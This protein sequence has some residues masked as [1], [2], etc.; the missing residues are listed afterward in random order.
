[1]RFHDVVAMALLMIRQQKTRTALSLIGVVIGSLM[2]LFSLASRRGVQDAVARV[3]SMSKEMRQIEVYTSWD[4]AEQEVPEEELEVHGEVDEAMRL[5]IREMLFRRWQFKHAGERVGLTRERIE[6]IESLQ[7]VQSVHPDAEI[8]VQLMQGQNE[9][10]ARGMAVAV[11]DE[12]LRERLLAGKAFESDSDQSILLNE[13]V[14]WKWGR[15]SPAKMHTLLGAKVRIEQRHGEE[16]VA[17]SITY[18][19]G[20]EIDFSEEE[21]SALNRAL[22]HIPTI[23][24]QLPLPEAERAALKKAFPSSSTDPARATESV[25]RI[26]SQEFTVVGIFRGPNKDE[27]NDKVRLGRG[28]GSAEFLLPLKTA[29]RLAPRNPYA[30]MVGL[31]G[32][33]VLVDHESHLETVSQQIRAMGLAEQSM[34][35]MVEYI[36]AR[37]RQV[38]LIVSL[39]AVFALVISALGITNTMVMS[40]V[41]RTREIGIMKALGARERQIQ[42]LFLVEGSLLGLIGGACAL[43]IGLVIRYPIESLT[44]SILENELHKTFEQQHLFEFP[45]WLLAIVLAFSTVVTTLAT[46]LPAW[47]AARIDPIKALRHD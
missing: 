29:T 28:D 43:M 35:R 13:F 17:Q 26:I 3:F 19:S 27:T 37:V 47:R 33:T 36:K 10:Q 45:W 39:V 46:I 14:A 23:I 22:D 32:A 31:N 11:G 12:V 15:S 25:E 38:T 6:S 1:M 8:Y 16:S 2:L 20:G 18:R 34:V 24:E 7:H 9:L 5:R 41:E 44:S 4:F 42:L 21:I 40:V 30:R